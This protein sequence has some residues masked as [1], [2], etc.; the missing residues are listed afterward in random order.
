MPPPRQE[1][2]KELSTSPPGA[3]ATQSLHTPPGSVNRR[4]TAIESASKSLRNSNFRAGD[5]T[6]PDVPKSNEKPA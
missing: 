6:P 1:R 4:R 5:V 3:S 2:Q